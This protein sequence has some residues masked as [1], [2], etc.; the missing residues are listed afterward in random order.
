M[1]KSLDV[2]IHTR[3]VFL[4]GLFFIEPNLLPVH[5]NEAKPLLLKLRKRFDNSS[6]AGHL[7]N[8][9]IKNSLIDKIVIG[10]NQA[11]QLASNISQLNLPF[12]ELN[13]REFQLSNES[14]LLPYNWPKLNI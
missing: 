4:Q 13:W 8:F 10:V 12:I 3:S 14:I 9:C 6:L 5:F 11:S 2:E 1:L 7:L